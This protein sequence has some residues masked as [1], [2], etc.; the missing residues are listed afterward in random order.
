MQQ[1]RERALM[2]RALLRWG[3]ERTDDLAYKDDRE[4]ELMADR[5][6]CAVVV[7]DLTRGE[8][9]APPWL[10]CRKLQSL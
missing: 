5:L 3:G 7:P 8:V 4:I 2:V 9:W 6:K 10:G 1:P